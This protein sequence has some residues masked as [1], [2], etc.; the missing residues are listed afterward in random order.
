MM[1]LLAPAKV[2][3]HLRVGRR[4]DDGFHPLLTWMCTVGLFD[5]LT[6]EAD[7]DRVSRAGIVPARTGTDAAPPAAMFAGSGANAAGLAGGGDGN[8]GDAGAAAA[9]VELVICGDG[10]RPDLPR[11]GSNLVARIATAFVDA[12]RRERS[13][14]R[15]PSGGR[16]R[17]PAFREEGFQEPRSPPAARAATAGGA[18]STAS[19]GAAPTR[20][21]G[22]GWEDADGTRD[23][24]RV[25]DPAADGS[26]ARGVGAVRD[27]ERSGRSNRRHDDGGAPPAR[28]A[29]R[30]LVRVALDKRIP[31]GAGLGGGSADAAYT[32]VALDRVLA[33]GWGA[34]RLSGFAAGFG[35]DVP[36]F[37]YAA[38]GSPSA[39]CRGRG[40]VVRAV[41]PPAARRAV[42]FSPPFALATRDVYGRFDEMGLGFDGALA[43]AEEPAWE[44]WA[45]LGSRELLARLVNDLEPA[46]FSLS[47][48]LAALRERIECDAGRVVRMSGSGSS[49]FTLFDAGEEEAAREAAEVGRRCGAASVVVAVAP[50][51]E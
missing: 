42:I 13:L 36:F 2:N 20:P 40:E 19:A 5:S 43:P 26:T 38:L 33:A 32:L 21:P 10:D 31:I 46:A 27:A 41:G 45:R 4:R 48:D 30:A 23:E 35:S 49:L 28:D 6:L 44:A 50:P 12:L 16:D 47:P 51:V 22:T 7:P 18:G 25:N 17:G 9:D 14:G 11:D 15:V 1:H 24:C 37:V 8:V 3:L 29:G 34:E 39:A